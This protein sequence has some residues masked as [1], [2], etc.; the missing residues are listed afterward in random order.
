MYRLHMRLT[1]R[2]L[3]W[4]PRLNYTSLM[5]DDDDNDNIWFCVTIDWCAL[6]FNP[7]WRRSITIALIKTDFSQDSLLN[8]GAWIVCATHARAANLACRSRVTWPV[9]RRCTFQIREYISSF[10]SW[11]GRMWILHWWR[12]LPFWSVTQVMGQLHKYSSSFS[13]TKGE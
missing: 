11:D 13:C 4:L 3:M 6:F 12:A 8:C 1:S 10:S 9:P 5:Q 2:K 7:H